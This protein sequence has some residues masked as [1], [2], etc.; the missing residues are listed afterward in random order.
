MIAIKV[1]AMCVAIVLISTAASFIQST[2]LLKGESNAD[3]PD[4]PFAVVELFTSQGC[5]SCPPAEA[6]L[7]RLSKEALN[8]PVYI[9]SYHVN[10]WD[11][12]GWKDVFSSPAFTKRQ[13]Q[14]CH[15]LSSQ[16]Y[17]PQLVING[18]SEFV[19]SD[20]PAIRQGLQT[21]LTQSS[22]ST[23]TLRSQVQA[24]NMELQYQLTGNTTNMQ[25]V[26]AVV[27]KQAIQK[28]QRGENEG[29]TLVHVQIV[30]QLYMYDVSAKSGKQKITLPDNFTTQDWEIIGIL[31]SKD[32]G[33]I[34]AATRVASTGGQSF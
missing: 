8:K 16:V 9:L 29:R 3:G 15:W 28:I 20:E 7:A 12:L 25:L 30:R 5:S 24:G 1:S 31:Q 17:T 11:H 19:G 34:S 27:Q 6:L 10:Y 33:V 22:L 2:T 21:T 26:I 18:S 14:Y 4:G 32:S 13:Y 23:L